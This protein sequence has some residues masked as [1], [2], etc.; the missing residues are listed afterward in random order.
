V[1]TSQSVVDNIKAE[2]LGIGAFYRYHQRQIEGLPED[3]SSKTEELD[4]KTYT[5]GIKN[6][7]PVG[8]SNAIEVTVNFSS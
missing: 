1:S 8:N 6:N 2:Q 7:G 3:L 5:I 4:G